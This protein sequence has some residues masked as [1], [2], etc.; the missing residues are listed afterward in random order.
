MTAS[1]ASGAVT[2]GWVD[3]VY[4]SLDW[5]CRHV[6][7]ARTHP[8]GGLG[9]P[10]TWCAT[11]LRQGDT[12]FLVGVM[13]APTATE[14]RALLTALRDSGM[15]RRRFERHQG[16]RRRVVTAGRAVGW[17]RWLWMLVRG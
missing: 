5:L 3:D 1:N 17:W 4:C 8:A 11:V 6:A 16:A 7:L 2:S 14:A 9:D 13:R 12:A 10:W 15:T